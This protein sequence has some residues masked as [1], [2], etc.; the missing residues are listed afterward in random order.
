[1]KILTLLA[2]MLG[3]VAKLFAQSDIPIETWRT[4]FSYQDC[5]IIEATPE[6]IYVAAQ[7]G[8]FYV[9][10]ADNSLQILSK[11]DGLSDVGVTAMH[12]APE[13]GLILAYQ[14]GVIDLIADGK[15]FPFTLIRDETDAAELINDILVQENSVYLSTSAGVRVLS[16]NLERDEPWQVQESYVRLGETG[17][18]VTVFQSAII[19]DSLFLATKA[20]VI[21]NTLDPLVNQ[22]DFS[23]WQRFDIV[24]GEEAMRYFAQSGDELF[25]A[26]DQQG[27]YRFQDGQW[28]PTLFRTE[29]NFTGLSASPN[30][31][32]I[33]SDGQAFRLDESGNVVTLENEAIRFA[34]DIVEV[35][36]RQWVADREQGLLRI[37][38][39]QAE[40][41]LPNGPATDDI[42][43][44]KP[45]NGLPIALKE[46]APGAYSVFEEGR[47]Q[48]YTDLPVSSRL[49][50]V[51]YSETTQQYY[52]ATLGEGV[53]QWDGQEAFSIIDQS[54]SGSTL[55]NNQIAAILPEQNRLW[56]ANYDATAALHLLNLEDNSWQAVA[57]NRSAARFPRQLVQ[58]FGQNIWIMGGSRNINQPGS[59]VLVF[60]PTEGARFSAVESINASNLPGRQ[61]TDMAID[62]D[63]QIWLTGTEGVAFFPVPEQVFD[64]VLSEKPIFDRQFLFLGDLVSAVATDGGNRKWMGTDAG[65]WLF[66]EDA[67][68]LVY[69]FTTENSPLPSDLIRDIAV[70]NRNGEVFIATDRGVVS[71]RSTA[72]KGGFAHQ[73]VKLFPNPV[74][75]G[76]DGLIGMQGL[77]NQAT[78]KITTVSG[79]LV[80]ELQ[81]EGG[82]ATWDLR[83][84]TGDRVQSGVYLVFSASA[85]GSETFVG[86]I[87][88]VP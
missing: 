45:A 32:L 78:V 23:T 3:G 10:R 82:T 38:N 39:G 56:V 40:Q 75:Q 25:V 33:L 16:L 53:L 24:A 37:A 1:M 62:L 58:D 68:E 70:D 73:S 19:G 35:E 80:Q 88:V 18:T 2:I 87:A 28:Q 49:M 11:T 21:A 48:N 57:F 59:D 7:H 55:D 51:A 9:N 81:A 69:N 67:E 4:H 27:V 30:G 65:L 66:S 13:F 42:F 6:R 50:D 83:A 60:N 31:L 41:L 86:K 77:V 8:L 22:Q 79:V 74:R 12:Y 43:K 85:D 72:T 84:Y 61:F 5:R 26:V 17:E 71:F 47:W 52:F 54:S 14:S 44:L 46:N 29:A 36:N 15:I 76:F 20:G 34:Q 63:G 64:G